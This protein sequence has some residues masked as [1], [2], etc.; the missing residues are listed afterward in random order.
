MSKAGN[1]FDISRVAVVTYLGGFLRS[2]LLRVL[3]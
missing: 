1:F 2:F 3:Q